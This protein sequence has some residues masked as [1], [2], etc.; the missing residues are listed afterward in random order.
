LFQTLVVKTLARSNRKARQGLAKVGSM[1]EP[2]HRRLTAAC[3]L[4]FLVMLIALRRFARKIRDFTVVFRGSGDVD[5]RLPGA[6]EAHAAVYMLPSAFYPRSAQRL[7]EE[8]ID[9][10]MLTPVLI[11]RLCALPPLDRASLALLSEMV[12][13]CK[14]LGTALLLSEPPPLACEDATVS[15][16]RLP[17]HVT[18]PTLDTALR[19]ARAHARSKGRICR[20]IFGDPDASSRFARP[21]TTRWRWSAAES[22][23]T[24]AR[25]R[26]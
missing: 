5:Q 6:G 14:R 23:A 16:L 1:N 9:N 24:Y 11:F 17:A 22:R 20:V 25:R 12:T 21:G 10:G 7:L 2:S 4:G 18:F 8:L 13:R 3:I 15:K 26:S 19:H